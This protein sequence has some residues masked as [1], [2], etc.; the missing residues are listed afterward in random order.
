MV[1]LLVLG[2]DTESH[3]FLITEVALNSETSDGLSPGY[4][5]RLIAFHI[6]QYPTGIQKYQ[7]PLKELTGLSPEALWTCPTERNRKHF[8]NILANQTFMNICL[9]LPTS[10]QIL[11]HTIGTSFSLHSF[12]PPDSQVHRTVSYTPCLA[13]NQPCCRQSFCKVVGMVPTMTD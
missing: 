6:P 4:R 10:G 5:A 9:V 11:D 12:Y 7:L 8:S 13:W 3:A 1:D 2:W